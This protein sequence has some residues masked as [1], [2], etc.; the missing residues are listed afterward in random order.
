MVT[1]VYTPAYQVYLSKR[2][3]FNCDYCNYPS[4]PSGLPPSPKKFRAHLRTAQRLGAWQI[5]LSSGEGIDRLAE[6]ESTCRY[7]GFEN[8]Y[9]YIYNLCRY[10][11]EA[12]GR[13]PLAPVLDIGPVPIMELRK[14]APVV[15]L[16][17][18]LLDSADAALNETV[19][20]QAPQKSPLLRSLALNDVGRAGIPLATGTRIGIGESRQSWSEA[21]EIVNEVHRKYGNV[22]A[23]HLIPFVPEPFSKMANYPP[24]TNEVFR[25]AVKIARSQL[26]PSITLVVEVHH[27][28]ALAA[29]SVVGGAFDFGPIRIADSERFDLDMLNAVNAVRGLLEKINVGME[30]APILREKFQREHRLPPL[31][32]SN[33]ARFKELG[34]ETHICSGV[35]TPFA[36]NAGSK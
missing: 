19:H 5:T 33:M 16:M 24:V 36:G 27:R 3:A 2:C 30:C 13:Q 4:V 28:L 22:M 7:Y 1:T 9:D 35:D 26:D 10:T 17:R 8:W 29:E 25:D 31:V 12:R 23:F 21:V 34:Q 6:I 14:L 11:L 15:P 32:E 20:A 18:L